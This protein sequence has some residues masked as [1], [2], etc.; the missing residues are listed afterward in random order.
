MQPLCVILSPLPRLSEN[1]LGTNR[2]VVPRA[3]CSGHV[4]APTL[5][6]GPRSPLPA[7]AP[8]PCAGFQAARVAVAWGPCAHARPQAHRRCSAEGSGCRGPS[9]L[10]LP[11]HSQVGCSQPPE[12]VRIPSRPGEAG[13]WNHGYSLHPSTVRGDTGHRRAAAGSTSSLSGPGTA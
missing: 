10:L 8:G 2:R 13:V 3:G 1:L 6:P 12:P 11:V 9:G 5:S 7:R 4:Q